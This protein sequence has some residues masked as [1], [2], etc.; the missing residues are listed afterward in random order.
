[1]LSAHSSV[2][3][4]SLGGGG[5][6][7]GFFTGTGTGVVALEGMGVRAGVRRSGVFATD[8]D[9]VGRA[10]ETTVCSRSW[11]N[12]NAGAGG[13]LSPPRAGASAFVSS[14]GAG[15]ESVPVSPPPLLLSNVVVVIEVASPAGSASGSGS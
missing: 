3:L 1:M 14:H 15:L 8:S 4:R 11:L 9:G 6:F 10:S 12:T 5:I 13:R 2:N 7:L